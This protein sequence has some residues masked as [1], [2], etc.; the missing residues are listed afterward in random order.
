MS[1]TARILWLAASLVV[2]AALVAGWQLIADLQ[3][4]SPIFL[5]GPSRAWRALVD[6]FYADNIAG[7]TAATVERMIYGWLLSSIV[8]VALGA[9][10]GSSRRAQAYLGPTLEFIRPLPASAVAPVAIAFLGLSNAMVLG[11]IVFGTLW[12]M[13][14]ATVHGFASVSPRLKEVAHILK[15]SRLEVIW[16]ISLPTAMPDI[17]AGMRLGLTVALILTIV[18]EMLTGQ[19]GLGRLI[20][21][22]ARS[23]QAPELYAGVILLGLVGL[24]SNLLL[25]LLD[26]WLLRWRP[27]R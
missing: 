26:R 20:L 6:G 10:I 5:P 1:V 12:P 14:L 4:I 7:Q 19:D 18:G 13:L 24:A 11:V 8:G 22:A 27:A 3:L 23:F 15:L 16:K 25:S 9:L 17:L 21:L 2:T